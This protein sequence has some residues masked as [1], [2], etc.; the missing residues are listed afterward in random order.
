M[1]DAWPSR[2]KRAS[3]Y[4]TLPTDMTND[5]RNARQHGPCLAA[6]SQALAAGN[7]EV[8]ALVELGA[9]LRPS[10]PAS[11]QPAPVRTC[12]PAP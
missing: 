9:D 2:R 6:L 5:Q 8:K 7:L 3:R 12:R 4:C 1:V 11:Y 10:T